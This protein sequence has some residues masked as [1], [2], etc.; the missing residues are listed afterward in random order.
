MTP[1]S[2]IRIGISSCLLG[3]KVRYDGGHKRDRFLTDTLG[4]YVQWVPVCPEVELGL[5]TPRETIHLVQLNGE[6]R[7]RSTKSQVDLTESMR[8]FAEQRVESLADEDLC[9]YVLKNDSPS[10]GMQ[11]VKVHQAKGGPKRE[12]QGVF[13]AALLSRFPN[14]PIEEEGRLCDPRLRENWVERIFAYRAMKDLWKPRWRIGHLVDFHARHKFALLAHS[15]KDFRQ[16]GRLVA[17]AKQIPREELREG[18]ETGFMTAMKRIATTKKNVNV[19]Q[20]M[21]GFFKKELDGPSRHEL[22]TQIEDYH[23]GIVPLIVPL[24]LIRH[25]VRVFD[26][27]YLAGQTYLNPHPK[28]LALRNHV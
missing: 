22:L 4:E 7:L 15:E 1:A 3:Q 21:L 12:G 5:G 26:I 2:P 20:H 6:V 23:R 18:Y 28:E 11:R 8:R 16:L 13:A 24:T 10:C 14:L 27:G 17:T 25:Y 19:L 9:G